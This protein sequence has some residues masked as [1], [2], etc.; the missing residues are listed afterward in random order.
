MRNRLATTSNVKRFLAGVGLL[1]A[2][3]A[4]EAS[5]LLVVG[6]P[7]YGKTEAVE[8]WA[9][10]VDAV[11]LCGKPRSTP[12]MVLGDLVREL[13]EQPEF[14]Y[15]KR[16]QQADRLLRASQRPIIL[17]EAQ[18]YLA[19]KAEALEAVRSLT[20]RYEIPL[21]L[22]SMEQ[23]QEILS[24][25]AQISSR[26]AAVVKMAPATVEDVRICCDALAEVKIAPCLV[27][28]I[29]HHTSGRYREIVNAIALVERFGKRNK[30]STVTRADMAGEVIANDWRDESP[31][32]VRPVR[33]T[34]VA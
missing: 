25:F 21:I 31:R 34:R 27:E 10:T 2:R 13:G 33:S 29:H 16:Y 12:H 9:D 5:M 8:R 17:D 4:R 22:V 15:E 32:Q 11:Y 20:D 14:S 18:F 28:E 23:I 19:E 1:E 7:G 24:R 3:G 26:I 30:L 6:D